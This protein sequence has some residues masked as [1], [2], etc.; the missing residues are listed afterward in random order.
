MTNRDTQS[1]VGTVR[2]KALKSFCRI[3]LECNS[4]Q[5][6]VAVTSQVDV[7]GEQGG[8]MEMCGDS[9]SGSRFLVFLESA[10]ELLSDA[11]EG[12]SFHTNTT[13]DIHITHV[14][15]YKNS[16]WI[17]LNIQSNKNQTKLTMLPETLHQ[18]MFNHCVADFHATT[19]M[20]FLQRHHQDNRCTEQNLLVLWRPWRRRGDNLVEPFPIHVFGVGFVKQKEWFPFQN[21]ATHVESGEKFLPTLGG[22]IIGCWLWGGIAAGVHKFDVMLEWDGQN[23]V[24]ENAWQDGR[25]LLDEWQRIVYEQLTEVQLIGR[26]S[27]DESLNQARLK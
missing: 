4:C 2:S 19:S 26:D 13:Q 23:A 7:S 5:H 15:G 27:R 20:V 22:R 21:P 18:N 14:S 12:K 1:D 11:W 9:R 24:D 10:G 16:K 25:I 8:N 6:C 3:S 17:N